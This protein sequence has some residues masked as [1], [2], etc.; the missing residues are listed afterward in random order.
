MSIHSRIYTNSHIAP[1]LI[2]DYVLY[3]NMVG[4]QCVTTKFPTGTA[5]PKGCSKSTI[6][7]QACLHIVEPKYD[8][9]H[10]H[11]EHYQQ[12]YIRKDSQ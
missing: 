5:D 6:L 4:S 9:M 3:G 8:S 12:T 2:L 10:K 11:T 7:H 1:I